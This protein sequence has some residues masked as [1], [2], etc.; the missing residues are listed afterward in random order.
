MKFRRRSSR[1]KTWLILVL[2]VVVLIVGLIAGSKLN[3]LFN[4]QDAGIQTS[5]STTATMVKNLEKVD[6]HVFL[7][8]G[9]QDIETRQNNLKIPWTH[10]GVPLTEKKAIIILNYDAKLGIKK[11]VKIKYNDK[12]QV[13]ITVPKFD[14]I[15]VELDRKNPYQLYDDSGNI[16]SASTKNV[17]T[18]Q[19][20]SQALSSSK[21]K[22]YLKTYKDMIQD[23]AKDYYTTLFKSTEKETNVKVNF[24]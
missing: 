18:G 16:L 8:V 23:S 5:Q 24:E 10:I 11:P 6:E 3:S 17:D 12:N 14:V 20:V 21:Q 22:H 19:L 15:G 1:T 4:N 13:D 2:L 9:I 7:N